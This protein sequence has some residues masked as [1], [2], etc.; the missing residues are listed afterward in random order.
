M[1]G[2]CGQCGAE[3]TTYQRCDHPDDQAERDLFNAVNAE[4]DRARAEGEA[5]AMLEA[6]AAVE[7]EAFDYQG[8][9]EAEL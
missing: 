1:S 6:A 8:A 3:G 7:A 9:P 5:M 2:R 4:R